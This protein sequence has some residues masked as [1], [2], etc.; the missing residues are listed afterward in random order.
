MD[1]SWHAGEPLVLPIEYYQE[2]FDRIETSKPP[3]LQ[4]THHFQTNA[5][6]ISDEFCRFAKEN[7]VSV[8]VSLDGPQ[9]IHDSNRRTRGGTGTHKQVMLGIRKLQDHQI[10]FA[11]IAV[12]TKRSLE[13]AEVLFDFFSSNNIQTVCFNLEESLGAHVKTS[14]DHDNVLSTVKAF[15]IRYLE[16]V[17]SGQRPQWVREIDGRLVQLFNGTNSRDKENQPLGIVTVNWRGD[18]SAFSPELLDISHPRHG[19]FIFGNVVGNKA[20]DIL[21]SEKLRR[22][23]AEIQE[24]VAECRRT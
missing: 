24:G 12:L 3:A 4:L 13:K 18:L 9:D 7:A 14:L 2:V 17:R 21:A 19:K 8:G 5:T 6:L 20:E 23:N 10:P 22:V 1:I 15:F 11:V 16:L